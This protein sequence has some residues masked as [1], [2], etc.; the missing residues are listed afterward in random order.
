MPTLQGHLQRCLVA[1]HGSPG[2]SGAPRRRH[3]QA[4]AAPFCL[5][6]HHFF[7][8]P[9]QITH[10]TLP[11]FLQTQ[12]K[13]FILLPPSKKTGKGRIYSQVKASSSL[14]MQGYKA[15]AEERATSSP[16]SAASSPAPAQTAGSWSPPSP[17]GVSWCR[18]ERETG[19]SICLQ[20]RQ[21]KKQGGE[22]V[23]LCGQGLFSQQAPPQKA[24]EDRLR[25]HLH[26]R[27]WCDQQKPCP[28]DSTPRFHLPVL[29][30]REQKDKHHHKQRLTFLL[31]SF[32]PPPKKPYGAL[33]IGRVA[34]ESLPA[35]LP[36]Q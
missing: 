34:M 1:P 7:S 2:N 8:S 9:L 17:A 11:A 12:L 13:I 14:R 22:G 30:V 27:W 25:G 15:W 16:T 23:S 3:S 36:A 4:Q 19:C 10:K 26:P 31:D 29:H 24:R 33:C 21:P 20:S 28:G 6:L 18:G 35:S 32:P 5:F